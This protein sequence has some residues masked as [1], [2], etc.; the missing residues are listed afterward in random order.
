MTL[1]KDG[2]Q[3]FTPQ[4]QPIWWNLHVVIMQEPPSSLL[5]PTC[6]RKFYGGSPSTRD[7]EYE[8]VWILLVALITIL[9]RSYVQLIPLVIISLLLHTAAAMFLH[10]MIIPGRPSYFCGYDAIQ[11][12]G[13][14]GSCHSET[15]E[16]GV[17]I[18]VEFRFQPVTLHHKALQKRTLKACLDNTSKC[19]V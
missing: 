15:D 5:P 1:G 16:K 17:P 9:I 11:Y 8:E 10:T 4:F 12:K 2:I 18:Q 7:W 14:A 13:L 19:I 6:F 3:P